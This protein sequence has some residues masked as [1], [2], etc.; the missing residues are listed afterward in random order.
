MVIL[1][2]TGRLT[3]VKVIKMKTLNNKNNKPKKEIATEIGDLSETKTFAEPGN[4]NPEMICVDKS[5]EVIRNMQTKEFKELPIQMRLEL[6]KLFAI[7]G[8][9]DTE[10]RYILQSYFKCT[11]Y[12]E[13]AIQWLK[14]NFGSYD[15]YPNNNKGEVLKSEYWDC[16]KRGN[17]IAEGIVCRP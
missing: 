9:S 17:C 11:T 5:Y 7:K 13:K 12:R 8:Y 10:C 14:C 6:I 3:L 1:F 4:K 16:G 2:N 15:K